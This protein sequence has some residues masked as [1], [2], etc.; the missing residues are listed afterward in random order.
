VAQQ[1][2]SFL[3]RK[4]QCS[5]ARAGKKVVCDGKENDWIASKEERKD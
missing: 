4:Q 1:T 3:H 2:F 5:E